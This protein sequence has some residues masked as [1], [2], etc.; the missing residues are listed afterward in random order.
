MCR[1][2]TRFTLETNAFCAGDERILR[3]R[4][5]HF[6]LETNPLKTHIQT[7]ATQT[8]LATSNFQT[9]LCQDD[10]YSQVLTS[11]NKLYHALVLTSKRGWYHALVLTS[12]Y[13]T[14]TSYIYTIAFSAG[15]NSLQVDKVDRENDKRTSTHTEL[16]PSK[17][18]TACHA[19]RLVRVW[20]NY[21]CHTDKII[22]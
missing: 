7:S 9:E 22:A 3:W 21:T 10:C 6:V 2:Q 13:A 17:L 20:P 18:I 14:L 1:R 8:Q 5:M 16:V 19:C 12:E 11:R 4:R 15:L